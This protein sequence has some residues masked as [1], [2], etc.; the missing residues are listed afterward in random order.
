MRREAKNEYD[1]AAYEELEKTL[2]ECRK[3]AD[4]DRRRLRF[5]MYINTQMEQTDIAE[6][7]LSVRSTNCLR[8]AGYHTVGQLADGISGID[9]L[10]RIRNCGKKSASEI[11]TRLLTY[12]YGL[13]SPRRQKAYRSRLLELNAD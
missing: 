12:Q 1:A 8:R 3:Y 13:L 11:M 2:A 9:D 10:S 5:P 4:R 6:L 7:E